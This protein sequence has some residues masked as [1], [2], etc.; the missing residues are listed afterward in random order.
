MFTF[1]LEDSKRK[2]NTNYDLNRKKILQV[3][4]YSSKPT[5]FVNTR[6]LREIN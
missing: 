6:I 3:N 2:K 1:I 5:L 4:D